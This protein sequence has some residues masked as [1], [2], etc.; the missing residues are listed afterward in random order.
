MGPKTARSCTLQLAPEVSRVYMHLHRRPGYR[1]LELMCPNTSQSYSKTACQVQRTSCSMQTAFLTYNLIVSCQAW[2]QIKDLHHGQMPSVKQFKMQ[3][4]LG[5]KGNVME[6]DCVPCKRIQEAK[7]PQPLTT[8][9][10]PGNGIFDIECTE[11]MIIQP[12]AKL[13]DLVTTFCPWGL[14]RTQM[15]LDLTAPHSKRSVIKL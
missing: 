13:S 10:I 4:S 8:T 12:G 9:A 5:L 1:H 15:L 6:V 7:L 11:K 2:A 14:L 3:S